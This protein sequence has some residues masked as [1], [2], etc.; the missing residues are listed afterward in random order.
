MWRW[1]SAP[2]IPK[3]LTSLLQDPFS[4]SA[5]APATRRGKDLLHEVGLLG[6][7]GPPSC[8]DNKRLWTGA[9]LIFLV[10][11]PLRSLGE[12]VL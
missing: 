7:Q 1:G 3:M 8:L 2:E 4:W 6:N 11:S 9:F 5:V 10:D 12:V